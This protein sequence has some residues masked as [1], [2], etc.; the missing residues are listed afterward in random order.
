M[1][2]PLVATSLAVLALFILPGCSS[3]Q[4]TVSGNVTVAGQPL[5]KGEIQF[6]PADGSGTPF[7]APIVD[8]KYT[9]RLTPGAKT[10]VISETL[11]SQAATSNEE[12][13]RMAA[14]G[15]RPAPAPEI[16]IKPETKGNSSHV[17]VTSETKT[18]DIHLEV[19]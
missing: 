16:R 11:D 1:R 18:L 8:G 19:N 13:Q 7:G 4:V 9:A 3:S 5:A 10:I 17:T 6:N 15:K 14:E 2:L 12:M